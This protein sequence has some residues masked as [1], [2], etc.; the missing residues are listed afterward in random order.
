LKVD[1]SNEASKDAVETDE[2]KKI[3]EILSFL[4]ANPSNITSKLLREVRDD[5]DKIVVE[6]S[7]LDIL[8][9]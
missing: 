6:S 5:H 2:E 4:V 1:V 9:T 8:F 3:K 7:D